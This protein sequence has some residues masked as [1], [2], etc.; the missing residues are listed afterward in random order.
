MSTDGINGI[1]TGNIGSTPVIEIKEGD[2]LSQIA[3][4][5]GTTIGNLLAANPGLSKDNLRAGTVIKISSEKINAA[6]EKINQAI[7][8]GYGEEYTFSIEP[9]GDI[10]IT[11]LDDME[12]GDIRADFKIPGGSLTNSNPGLKTKYEPEYVIH[13]DKNNYNDWD[14]A[15]ANQ[16]DQFI[17]TNA[18]FNPNKNTNMWSRG[19]QNFRDKWGF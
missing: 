13:L 18:H 7:D 8:L 15:E 19:W 3:E 6:K 14:G 1:S 2:T 11:L 9:N 12:L 10:R 16:G 4:K 5:Y 17:I